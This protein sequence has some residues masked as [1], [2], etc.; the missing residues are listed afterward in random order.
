MTNLEKFEKIIDWYSST[1]QSEVRPLTKQPDS[2]RLKK[3]SDEFGIEIPE[4]M[5]TLFNK[6]DGE[7][8]AGYSAFMGHSLV[9]IG[10]L[11]HDLNFSKSLLKPENPQIPDPDKAESIIKEICKVIK[12]D[13]SLERTWFKIEIELGEGSISGPY[14]YSKEDSSNN[15]ILKLDRSTKDQLFESGHKLHNL[16]KEKYNWD[17]IDLTLLNNDSYTCTRKFYKWSEGLTSTP[18]NRIKLKYYHLKWFP[19]ISDNSGN[20]IGID[21]DPD[22]KGVKGQVIV[23]GRDE[24]DMYVVANSWSDFLD[25][26]LKLIENKTINTEENPHLHDLYKRVLNY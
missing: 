20:Y 11:S 18:P 14:L 3:L 7:A 17:S 19:V 1:M 26:N 25:F 24:D 13:I 22:T 5:V 15:E 4:D 10:K 16:E 12:S 2:T 8:G 21:L 6:Y 23:F 9:S